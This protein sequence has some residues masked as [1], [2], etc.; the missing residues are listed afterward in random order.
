MNRPW[1][2]Q[3][4][5]R[6]DRRQGDAQVRGRQREN[7]QVLITPVAEQTVLGLG[8]R[9]LSVRYLAIVQR[10]VLRDAAGRAHCEEQIGASGMCARQVR[11]K[12]L[13]EHGHRREQ[14]DESPAL[15]GVHA[16]S[17]DVR[18]A[19]AGLGS[20]LIDSVAVRTGLFGGRAR[21][22]GE[23]S[24]LRRAAATHPTE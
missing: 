3:P 21:R 9:G 14:R 11:P 10:D 2:H 1:I 7:D 20:V 6:R 4:D 12:H 15:G 13:E 23:D 22:G 8:V 19:R 5:G 17:R 24:I 16:D 18:I